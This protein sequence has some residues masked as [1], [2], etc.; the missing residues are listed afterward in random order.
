MDDISIEAMVW[1]VEPHK[2]AMSGE[3]FIVSHELGRD[4]L[5]QAMTHAVLVEYMEREGQWRVRDACDSG[6]MNLSMLMAFRDYIA[7][8]QRANRSGV[9]HCGWMLERGLPSLREKHPRIIEH[10]MSIYNTG[11]DN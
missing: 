10:I 2:F 5:G 1:K 11:S 3:F 6:E 8:S 9:G 4:R 7:K